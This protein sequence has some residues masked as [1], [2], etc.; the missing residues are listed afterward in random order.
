MTNGQ[1]LPGEKSVVAESG[2][3]S[4]A[5]S[6]PKALVNHSTLALT[7]LRFRCLFLSFL[8]HHTLFKTDSSVLRQHI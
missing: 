6:C 8:Y 5:L 7:S 3:W 4:L 1:V 2:N